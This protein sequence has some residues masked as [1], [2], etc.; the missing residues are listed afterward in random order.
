MPHINLPNGVVVIEVVAVDVRV[1]VNE[2]LSVVEGVCVCVLDS[3]VVCDDVA[4][5]DTVELADVVR[6]LDRDVVPLNVIVVVC[7]VEF[8][9]V[10]VGDEDIEEV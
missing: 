1:L 7:E 6:V 2:A 10:K 3:D 9:G 4:V 8:V 5:I